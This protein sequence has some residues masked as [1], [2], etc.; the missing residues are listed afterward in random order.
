[1]PTLAFRYGEDAVRISVASMSLRGDM[2]SHPTDT[3]KTASV[4][5]EGLHMDEIA[6]DLNKSDLSTCQKLAILAALDNAQKDIANGTWN[7]RE[8][9]SV[10]T[11]LIKGL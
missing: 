11:E 6:K 4:N 2:Q 7:Q 5:V 3:A 9:G 1:M 8:Y 10:V